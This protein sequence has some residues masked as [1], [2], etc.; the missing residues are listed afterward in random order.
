MKKSDHM[1]AEV[2]FV[3]SRISAEIAITIAAN[4]GAPEHETNRAAEHA[5]KKVSR[6]RKVAHESR[7]RKVA[8]WQNTRSM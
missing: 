2:W 6:H 3:T 4:A 1:Y 7:H 5:V 8:Y